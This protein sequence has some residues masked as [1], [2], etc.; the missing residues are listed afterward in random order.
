ML[1]KVRGLQAAGKGRKPG[2]PGRATEKRVGTVKT[3]YEEQWVPQE[4]SEEVV[5]PEP[6]AHRNHRGRTP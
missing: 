1:Q 6:S 2:T 3:G 5:F 4:T